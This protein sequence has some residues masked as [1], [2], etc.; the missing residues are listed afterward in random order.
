MSMIKKFRPYDEIQVINLNEMDQIGAVSKKP[1]A[2]LIWKNITQD[3][4][5]DLKDKILERCGDLIKSPESD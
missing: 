3:E 2:V 1:F 4:A 5:E